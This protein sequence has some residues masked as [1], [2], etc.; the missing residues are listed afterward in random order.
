MDSVTS[1]YQYLSGAI[2]LLKLILRDC[3]MPLIYNKILSYLAYIVQ[4]GELLL[5]QDCSI[6][7]NDFFHYNV[8]DSLPVVFLWK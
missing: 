7:C 3:S 2:R 8:F 4:A 6:K 5:I 1:G